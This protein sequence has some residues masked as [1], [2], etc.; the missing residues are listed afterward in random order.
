MDGIAAAEDHRRI[1]GGVRRTEVG[2]VDL[3]AVEVELH[4]LIEGDRRPGVLRIGLLLIL[5]R[6]QIDDVGVRH[7]P[8][9]V[10]L[11]HQPTALR[12]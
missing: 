7:H 5:H 12:T 1:A 2:Q 4:R 11:G 9:R 8:P 3:L 6:H 10:G